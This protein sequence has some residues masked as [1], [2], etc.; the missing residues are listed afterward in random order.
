MNKGFNQVEQFES[1]IAQFYDAPYG[2]AVDCCTH[3]L[4]LC[5]RYTQADKILVPKQTYLSVAM[6]AEK[7]NIHR[8]FIDD[9]WEN[10][11]YLTDKIVDAAVYWEKNSYINGTF[12]VLSFQFKKHLSLGRGGMI[13][14]D[15]KDAAKELKKMSYDGRDN[16]TGPWAEQNIETIG[17]HYYMT[18]ETA[19]LGL[20]KLNEAIGTDAKKWSWKDYPDLTKMKFRGIF[21]VKL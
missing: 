6:L 14:T 11:Y 1:A 8:D 19:Q 2:V 4:E 5:L 7:L 13:L 15:N 9:E 20:D 12:M 18:P 16:N 3:G 10:Y 17:Y 21:D